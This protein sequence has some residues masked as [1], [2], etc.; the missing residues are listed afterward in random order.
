MEAFKNSLIQV[1]LVIIE[2]WRHELNRVYAYRE[3]ETDKVMIDAYDRQI[4][5]RIKAIKALETEVL[6]LKHGVRK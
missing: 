6:N 2:E 4:D 3:D 5:R 1:A